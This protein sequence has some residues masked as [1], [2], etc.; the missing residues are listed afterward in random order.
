MAQPNL[1]VLEEYR[2][3][4]RDYAAKAAELDDITRHRDTK[5]QAY[6]DMRKRRLDEFMKGFN[7]ISQ[8][9]KEMYQVCLLRLRVHLLTAA[10]MT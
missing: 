10:P 1:E 3:R 9:L 5:K 8:K 7:I 2:E 6:D 4:E